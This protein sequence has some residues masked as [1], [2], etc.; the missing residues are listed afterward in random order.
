MQ[1]LQLALAAAS[2]CVG[3]T[4]Q[5][6]CWYHFFKC[7]GCVEPE[8]ERIIVQATSSTGAPKQDNPF[9]NPNV[10]RDSHLISA[11]S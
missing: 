7:C 2:F 4:A 9:T 5:G 1:A 3:I 10:P 11:Y 6:C 8:R